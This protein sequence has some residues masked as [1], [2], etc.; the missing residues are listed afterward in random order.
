MKNTERER[1]REGGEI[2]EKTEWQRVKS[3]DP[4]VDFR[5]GKADSFPKYLIVGL[6]SASSRRT[7]AL[8]AT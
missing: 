8:K 6:N 3:I 1:E 5:P 7:E 4:P 2:L